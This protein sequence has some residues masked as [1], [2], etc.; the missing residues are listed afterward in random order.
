[1]Q[2]LQEQGLGHVLVVVLVEDE[3]DQI[4]PVVAAGYHIGGEWGHQ[5]LALG[6]QP[7][8][9]AVAD[10]A[11]FEDLVLNDEVLVASED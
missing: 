7:A 4:G 2:L 1:V 10:D 11:R 6:G 5:A 8:F 3:A 9:A